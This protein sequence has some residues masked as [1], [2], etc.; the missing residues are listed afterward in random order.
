MDIND[1]IDH[2]GS[3]NETA[4]ALGIRHSTICRWKRVG[5]IPAPRQAQIESVTRGYLTADEEPWARPNER[6]D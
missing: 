3:V 1:V 5:R 2:F 6:I 4:D